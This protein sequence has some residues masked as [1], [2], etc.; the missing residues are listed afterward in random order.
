MNKIWFQICGSHSKDQPEWT[1]F[2]DKR[3]FVG[4]RHSMED[5]ALEAMKDEYKAGKTV[6]FTSLKHVDIGL[7]ECPKSGYPQYAWYYHCKI[8][9]RDIVNYAQG[10]LKKDANAYLI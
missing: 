8:A 9:S 3:F 6:H 1:L 4:G 7:T 10:I 2:H 5:P